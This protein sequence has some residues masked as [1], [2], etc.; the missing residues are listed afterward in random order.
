MSAPATVSE[1]HFD[2]PAAFAGQ[3]G[4][5]R[6]AAGWRQA[7]GG[8]RLASCRPA[9]GA[10]AAG[11]GAAGCRRGP[12]GGRC[13]RWR[14]AA[15]GRRVRGR[16]SS[17]GVSTHPRAYE[18]H[19]SLD[20][21][22]WGLPVASGKGAPGSTTIVLERRCGPAT[23]ASRRRGPRTRRP[24][25]S[26][27]CRSTARRRRRARRRSRARRSLSAHVSGG[28]PDGQPSRSVSVSVL[29]EQGSWTPRDAP[30]EDADRKRDRRRRRRRPRAR[31]HRGRCSAGGCNVQ[32]REPQRGVGRTED[33]ADSQRSREPEPER[34]AGR[35]AP[36]SRR[37]DRAV[38][39]PGPAGRYDDEQ[40]YAPTDACRSRRRGSPRSAPRWGEAA[41]QQQADHGEPEGSGRK[42]ARAARN[43]H[44]RI[45]F[46]RPASACRSM[47]SA[48]PLIV[49]DAL[50]ADTVRFLSEPAGAASINGD[51]T[52]MRSTTSCSHGRTVRGSWTPWQPETTRTDG[53]LRVPFSSSAPPLVVI[54]FT[55][56]VIVGPVRHRRRTR[57]VHVAQLAD[58][59]RGVHDLRLADDRVRLEIPVEVDLDAV[60]HGR[61]SGGFAIGD[62]RRSVVDADHVVVHDLGGRPAR[63]LI[64][65]LARGL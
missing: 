3:G 26:R 44:G 33:R 2:S 17:A 27:A 8:P 25:A 40:E 36:T 21:Q 32:H 1:I 22:K 42:D 24:G 7:A 41:D 29:R 55:V 20:G 18:V 19:V 47:S 45:V 6:S 58:L 53:K 48:P 12:G 39:G 28:R 60:G 62:H 57:G 14:G 37:D 51:G 46:S 30:A 54:V 64:G 65:A 56:E 50:S 4:R 23:S 38:R 43:S 13:R 35:G 61:L 5:R 15:A 11:P 49:N 31:C 34:A 52:T 63:D 16:R 10:A 9:P 59:R